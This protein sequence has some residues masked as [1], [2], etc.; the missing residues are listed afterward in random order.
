MRLPIPK[1]ERKLCRFPGIL[2]SACLLG[3]TA[4]GGGCRHADLAERRFAL[5]CNRVERTA[6]AAAEGERVRVAAIT[7]TVNAI[8]RNESRH[9]EA[10]RANLDELDAYWQRDCQRW[11]ERQPI[12]RDEAW[13]I[14]RGKA[15]RIESNAIILFF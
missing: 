8:H 10:S 7:R 1:I 15:D 12:Y 14:L 4:A 13:R 9:V 6:D 5:R 11:I 3:L 2:V